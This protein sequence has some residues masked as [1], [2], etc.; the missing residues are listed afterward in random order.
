MSSGLTVPVHQKERKSGAGFNALGLLDRQGDIE[1]WTY[2]GLVSASET[3]PL[4][5]QAR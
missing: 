2:K 3:S 4:H 5:T 1:N